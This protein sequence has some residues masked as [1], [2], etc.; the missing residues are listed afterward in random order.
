L[1]HAAVAAWTLPLLLAPGA[2]YI[3]EELWSQLG[4][5]FSVHT[6]A[7]PEWDEELA[8]E[9]TI[10][11]VVQVNGKVRGHVNLPPDTDEATAL[12]AARANDRVAEHLAGKTV[13][14]EVYVPRRL[15]NFVVR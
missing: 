1:V 12:D 8:A 15:I 10:E 13:V 3:A 5:P 9:E 11:I 4:K 7:W 2:P 6:Q 14:K